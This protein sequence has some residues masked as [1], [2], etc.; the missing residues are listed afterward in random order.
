MGFV[1]L[2]SDPVVEGVISGRMDETT[3]YRTVRPRGSAS[4]ILFLT[5][6][7]RG[8]WVTEGE[9]GTVGA[10]EALLLPPLKA[11]DY[12]AAGDE[13]SFYWTHFHPPAAWADLLE[14]R[15][16]PCDDPR[17][18]ARSL[19]LISLSRGNLRLAMNALEEILIRLSPP[20]GPRR[21]PRIE[22]ALAH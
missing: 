22:S 1:T 6:A 19:D 17:I 16:T 2:G 13:W 11:Q 10:G 18:S 3:G 14:W 8:R 15:T 4:W 20:K 12:G 7:G 5:L 9:A 21:D